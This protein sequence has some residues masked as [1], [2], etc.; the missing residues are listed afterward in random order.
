M[1]SGLESRTTHPPREDLT[2]H[3]QES[4]RMFSDPQS[5]TIDGT[6]VSLPKVSSVGRKGTYETPDGAVVLTINHTNGKRAWSTVRIDRKKIGPD[7]MNPSVNRQISQSVY[8]V[9]DTP[10]TGFT[11]LETGNDLKGLMAWLT[12]PANLSKFLGGES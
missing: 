5:V 3:C 4:H 11:D 1:V 7:V 9:A 8:I 12:V 2:Q 6:A 10:L